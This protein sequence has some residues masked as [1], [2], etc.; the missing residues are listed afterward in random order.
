[1]NCFEAYIVEVLQGR[2]TYNKQPVEVRRQFTI[3]QN[4]PCITL[5]TTNTETEYHYHEQ[6]E[7]NKYWIR[8]TTT[9]N[10]NL[11]CNTEDER[12]SITEDILDCFHKEL[13]FH[14][15]FCS[16][17]NNGNCGEDGICDYSYDNMC[18]DPDE[19][20]Y[21]SLREKY[22]IIDGTVM[23]NPPFPLNEYDRHPALLRNVF[24]ARCTYEEPVV[25]LETELVETVLF[26]D[27]TLQ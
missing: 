15:E 18:S 7:D 3:E 16:K 14:H 1:M 11:W 20:E 12:E 2:I 23:V 6:D 27:I 26:D 22:Y 4:L 10:I 17:Y 19:Y 5:N 25:D 24:Q 8:Y 21:M 9:I 13:T